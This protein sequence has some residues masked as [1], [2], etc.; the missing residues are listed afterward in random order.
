MGEGGFHLVRGGELARG[1]AAA[2]PER[3]HPHLEREEG[4]EVGGCEADL[5][6][7][8]IRNEGMRVTLREIC[9][10]RRYTGAACRLGQQL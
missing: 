10:G 6:P 9:T 5:V 3:F 7:L 2:G 1:G 8:R 4:E